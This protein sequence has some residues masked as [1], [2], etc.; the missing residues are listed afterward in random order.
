[1]KYSAYKRNVLRYGVCFLYS[2][3]FLITEIAYTQEPPISIASSVDKSRITIGDLITYSITVSHDPDIQVQMPGLGANLGGFE[4]RDYTVLDPQKKDGK[5]ISRWDYSISTF[6]T[7][8]FEVPPLNVQYVLPGDTI[9]KTLTTEKIKIVVESVKPSEAGDI[10][11]IKPPVEIPGKLWYTL[12]WIIMGAG[13][14]A[15]VLLVIILYRRRKAGKSILPFRE[16]PPRPPHEIA[17]EALY[18]LRNSDLLANGKI[19][20]F[21]SELSE[22]IRR[23]IEGRYYIIALEM[24]TTEV[25]EGLAGE[26]VS[27]DVYDL[28][29]D[30]LDKCDLVKFAKVIPSEE[31]HES[32]L[33][34]AHAIVDGTKVIVEEDSPEKSNE[35]D[36]SGINHGPIVESA[37]VE[38]EADTSSEIQKTGEI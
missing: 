20:Q 8:E 27:E 6:F 15:L 31:E 29:Q 28:F 2:V 16:I 34:A 11:D 37:A 36:V 30:F 13:L 9:P 35:T 25:L 33:S 1:M 32:I 12:R 21:Y 38:S 23:Y 19:K 22:I 14:A 26:A 3:L 7:G 17:F 10:R 4:I 18:N 5:T 24:T